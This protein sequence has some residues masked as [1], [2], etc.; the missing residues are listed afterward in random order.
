MTRIDPGVLVEQADRIREQLDKDPDDPMLWFG[1]GRI[2][3]SLGLPAEA[4]QP[5]LAAIRL[6]PD[7]TAAFR[8]LG[9]AHLECGNPSEAARVFAHA[10]ALAEKAGDCQTGREIHVFL[11]QAEKRGPFE[12]A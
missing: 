3:L 6:D 5:F 12:G 2:Y 4:V 11:K 8:D 1:L 10:I 7:Y 9:R